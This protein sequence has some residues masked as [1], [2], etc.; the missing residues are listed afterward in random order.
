MK[1]VLVVLIMMN[2][3]EAKDDM[4]SIVREMKIEMNERIALMEGKQQKT[5]EE[6][7]KTQMELKMTQIEPHALKT[8]DIQLNPG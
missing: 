3:G 2:M 5:Q 7:R 8:K 1:R 6:L 4:E